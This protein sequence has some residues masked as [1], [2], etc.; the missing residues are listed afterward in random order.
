[1]E[2]I[3]EMGA[4]AD[5]MRPKPPLAGIEK[6]RIQRQVD[7]FIAADTVH[8]HVKRHLRPDQPAHPLKQM[9][10]PSPRIMAKFAALTDQPIGGADILQP[11]WVV[12]GH[13]PAVA[14]ELVHLR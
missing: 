12:T 5:V 9:Q 2:R 6:A 1:M 7:A 8:L 11:K 10:P 3:V 13:W 4:G 14:K